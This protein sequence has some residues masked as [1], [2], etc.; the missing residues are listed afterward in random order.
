[1]HDRRA[2]ESLAPGAIV[3]RVVIGFIRRST[4]TAEGYSTAHVLEC[5]AS[6][7]A[8]R[9]HASRRHVVI[10]RE[11]QRDDASATVIA[12]RVIVRMRAVG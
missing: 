8:R 10:M 5:Q 2:S 12:P 1:V 7:A 6:D 3:S 9:A 4:D 11:T